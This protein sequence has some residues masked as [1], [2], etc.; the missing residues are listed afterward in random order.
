[1]SRRIGE[2]RVVADKVSA[3][4]TDAQR[5]TTFNRALNGLATRLTHSGIVG[6]ALNRQLDAFTVL[7]N[8]ELWRREGRQ[9]P[10]GGAA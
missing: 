10:T 5:Q 9:R 4:A 3:K 7:V 2:A 8:A 6:D 1:M